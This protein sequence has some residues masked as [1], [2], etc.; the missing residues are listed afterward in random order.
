MEADSRI[1]LGEAV[2]YEEMDGS[3][4]YTVNVE[5]LCEEGDGGE[6][7]LELLEEWGGGGGG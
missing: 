6:R 5:S 1:K 7:W 2:R 4:I 3:K